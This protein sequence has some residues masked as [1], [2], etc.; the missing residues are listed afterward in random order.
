MVYDAPRAVV[1]GGGD[2]GGGAFEFFFCDNILYLVALF[3][4]V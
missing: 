1:H 3:Y 4:W 2:G